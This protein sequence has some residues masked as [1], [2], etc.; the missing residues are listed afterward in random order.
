M[1]KLLIATL[2]VL[3]LSAAAHAVPMYGYVQITTTTA[4]TPTLQNGAINIASGTMTTARHTSL[5]VTSAGSITGIS[6]STITYSSATFTS[7]NIGGGTFAG[8][9]TG[10]VNNTS[11]ITSTITASSATLTNAT[12]S[13]LAVSSMTTTLPMS[14]RKITGLANGSAANDAT[15]FGQL[16]FFG[17]LCSSATATT[18]ST[19]SAAFVSTPLG[20]TAT[21]SDA[22]HHALIIA[23]GVLKT[24]TAGAT[25]NAAIFRDSTNLDD[26]SQG[27]AILDINATGFSVGATPGA[28]LAYDA[29]G[30]TNAHA[31][32]V[33][34]VTGGGTGTFGNTA[35]QRMVVMETN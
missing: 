21:L 29:P 31:Y 33:K 11:V 20:C 28:F 23:T 16:R 15:A 2:A 35:T 5:T 32:V 26:S 25:L 1:R 6:G 19:T 10:A 27:Q 3:G 24:V 13:N 30:D 18:F 9:V 34:I 17:V 12:V 14:G 4:L 7:A 8:T 22:T